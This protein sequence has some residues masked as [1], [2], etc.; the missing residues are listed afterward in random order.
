MS[1]KISDL[2]AGTTLASGDLFAFVDVS[3]TTMAASGTTKKL[4]FSDLLAAIPSP[5][6]TNI[7][8]SNGTLTSNRTLTMGTYSLLFSGNETTFRGFSSTSSNFA[9]KVQNS[10][11]E[12]MFNIVNSGRVNVGSNQ[13]TSEAIFDIYSPTSFGSFYDALRIRTQNGTPRTLF[14]ATNYGEFIFNAYS[15]AEAPGF[16]ARL[17]GFFGGAIRHVISGGPVEYSQYAQNGR[18][19]I[20]SEITGDT[21]IT[22]YNT[23]TNSENP[24]NIA[25]RGAGAVDAGFSKIGFSVKVDDGFI[26]LEPNKLFLTPV[27]PETGES[28]YLKFNSRA[29]DG[30]DVRSGSSTIKNVSFDTASN[31]SYLSVGEVIR[32]YRDSSNNPDYVQIHIPTLGLKTIEVGA[33]DSGGTGYRMLRVLN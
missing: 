30:T 25:R 10:A 9:L 26:S 20:Q 21:N 19:T 3:D 14:R 29:T 33:V 24:I 6:S 7:Y 16:G 5:P 15:D 17:F 28:L 12:D 32:A 27:S 31:A 13:S 11:L 8:N 1:V 18:F 2:T 22:N 23:I 4:L